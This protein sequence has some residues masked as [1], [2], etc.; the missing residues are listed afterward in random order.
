M[1][2]DMRMPRGEGKEELGPSGWEK[3][4]KCG[5][6]NVPGLGIGGT[7]NQCVANGKSS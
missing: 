7:T 6:G 1:I 3:R 2:N 5:L 4:Q